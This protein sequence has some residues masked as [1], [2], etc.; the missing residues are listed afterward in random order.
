MALGD[1][2]EKQSKDRQWRRFFNMETWFS[3]YG[4]AVY[5]LGL[6]EGDVVPVNGGC[7][8]AACTLG[9]APQRANAETRRRRDH[10]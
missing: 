8:T 1:Y 4:D 10:L 9:H 2:I 3:N 7:G 6:E 5:K